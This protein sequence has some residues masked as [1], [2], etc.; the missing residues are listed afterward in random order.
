VY[1]I[2]NISD[3]ATHLNP[4]SSLWSRA[5]WEWWGGCVE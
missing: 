3:V 4:L 5:W 1:S 2:Y